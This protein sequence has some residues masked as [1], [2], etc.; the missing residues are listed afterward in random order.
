MIRFAFKKGLAFLEG[1]TAWTVIKQVPSGKIQLENA[2][3]E[4]RSL[5]PKEIN[6]QWLE[7]K[8][9][10]DQRSLGVAG[11]VF[12]T[13]TPRDLATYSEEDQEVARYRFK[14]LAEVE[15]RLGSFLTTPWRLQKVLNEIA[16]DA[17]EAQAPRAG[18]VCKWWFKFRATRCITKLIDG[19]K[20]AGR[21]R[22][23]VVYG[24]F[25][26]AIGEVYLTTQKEQ[27]KTVVESVRGK[28]KRLNRGLAEDQQVRIPHASTIYRWLG[29]LHELLVQKAR[30]G[31]AAAEKEFRAAL[32]KLK[33]QRILER[34]EI[35][36]TPLDLIVLCAVTMLPLGRPW[37]TLA[38][39]RHSRMIMGFYISFH[40]PSSLSVLQVL[41]RSILPKESLLARF[42]DITVPWPARGIMDMVVFDNGMDLHSDAVEMACLDMGVEIL[43]LPPAMPELK[44]A[45]ERMMR[46][47]NT[48][49]IHSLPGTVFSNV[50]QR[51]DYPSEDLAAIDMETLVH[52][53]TKWIV[54]IYH[55][56]VHRG[57]GMA[58]LTKWLEGEKDRVIELPAYPQQLE[59]LV[60]IPANRTIFHYGIE[61][62]CLRYNCP[63]LQLIRAR[64]GGTPTVLIKGYEDDAGFIHVFDPL[65]ESYIRVPAVDIEYAQGLTRYM[66][67]LVRQHARKKFGEQW[68]ED[69][70]LQSKAEIQAIVAAAIK[71]KKMATRKKGAVA[72]IHDSEQVLAGEDALEAALKPVPETKGAEEEQLAPGL[73]DDLPDYGTW[74]KTGTEG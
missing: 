49:L 24:L 33:V 58:P 25:E 56:T 69:E 64:L 39:D 70:L 63:E 20:R 7:G 19:R 26:E 15:K 71:S 31:K 11:N 13:A 68:S 36:H 66:H 59:I 16:A 21:R 9:V 4:V 48:G 55:R 44:G 73:E 14:Y 40:P 50:D 3:G 5:E 38:I 41:K 1:F 35:D 72:L 27:G 46:T 32:K 34:V 51:G 6:Q 18:T 22:D 47:L 17:G 29:D 23:A 74:Q 2:E 67:L 42:P 60:G 10:V 12:Y 45:I 43:Y 37:L 62:D 53:V 8:L 57:I 52:L 28:V 61:Y 65:D 30:L 54:E